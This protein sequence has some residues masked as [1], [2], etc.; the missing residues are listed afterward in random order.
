MTPEP[1]PSRHLAGL[2]APV[3]ALL[4][5]RRLHPAAGPFLQVRP[6]ESTRTGQR[7]VDAWRAGALLRLTPGVYV[8]LEWWAALPRWDRFTVAAAAL[9]RARPQTVFTGTTAAHLHGLPL[10][11]VPD[12]LDVRAAHRGHRPPGPLAATPLSAAGAARVSGQDADGLLPPGQRR[13][14]NV[15]RSPDDDGPVRVTA[16]LAD[17]TPVGPVRVDPL[18]TVQLLT[19]CELPFAEAIAPLDALAMRAW[20]PSS[21]W[22]ERNREV[23]RTRAGRGRFERAWGFVDPRSESA[24][25]SFSRA[26]LEELGFAR[27]ELQRVIH[28]A[29]GRFAGRVD[30]WWE[31]PRVTG[32][33]DGIGKYDIDLH[34]SEADRRRSIGR[35][36]E[37]D[38]RLAR[39][40]R[41][42]VHWTWAD[43]W[44]PESLA[45]D[46]ARA[47]VPRRG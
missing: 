39:L 23:W 4:R 31:G 9:A 44:R 30:F 21:R 20:G 10:V 40:V 16:T 18:C 7:L 36:A 15:P 25:E 32:E 33:F 2:P 12:L 11:T 45:A 37:R 46:L 22:A 6:E 34:A 27:P 14:W 47:G 1:D 19:A 5:G 24:G 42:Q 28:D 3:L 26:V 41:A 29:A 17:G 38:R 13:R 8:S 43:L 35:E